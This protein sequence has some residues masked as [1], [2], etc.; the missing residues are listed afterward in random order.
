[1]RDLIRPFAYLTVRHP[2]RLPLWVNWLLPLL[3]AT[4]VLAG[5]WAL[6]ERVNVYGAQG[7]LERLLSFVQTLVGFYIAALAAVSSFNSPHL[8]REMPHPAPTMEVKHNGA[9]QTVAAT[10][11][12]FLTSMFAYLTALSFLFSLAA[13]AVLVLAGPF[14]QSYP[15]LAAWLRPV[16]LFCFLVALFQTTC[17]T[18]WGLFYLGERMLTPD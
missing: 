6:K 16:G 2:S 4:V 5:L 14:G 10:R 15:S 7:L 9:L 17:I 18:F 12:R 3:M 8:D 13:V 11:R 1:M